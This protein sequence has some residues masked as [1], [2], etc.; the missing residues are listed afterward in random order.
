M[1]LIELVGYCIYQ[2]AG[3]V[4]LAF[5]LV[6]SGMMDLHRELYRR[7]FP[8]HFSAQALMVSCRNAESVFLRN[9]YSFA[10]C[11]ELWMGA[12]Q[13]FAERISPISEKNRGYNRT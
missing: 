5:L 3:F 13:F 7:D 4:G 2:A 10:F 12:I 11:P 1:I 9:L 6:F 8:F